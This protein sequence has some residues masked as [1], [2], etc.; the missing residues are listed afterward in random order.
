[1]NHLREDA[2]IDL[3][4]DESL[5]SSA[6]IAHLASCSECTR[7]VRLMREAF[8]TG[9]LTAGTS[10]PSSSLREHVLGLVDS[11]TRFSG[12]VD[13]VAHHFDIDRAKAASILAEI[14]RVA[15]WEVGPI[16]GSLLLHL[17]GGPRVADADAGL[18]YFESG[19]EFPRHDHRGDEDQIILQGGFREPS[20]KTYVAG[21]VLKRTKGDR[22]SFV[23]HTK[24]AC[25]VAVVLHGG[26]IELV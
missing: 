12:F 10:T 3:A 7:E 11:A 1:M 15:T 26:D 22:H 14:D 24:E 20:G 19:L 18:V 16:P 25:I 8:A 13:R 5:G 6:D 9:A 4:M 2:L 23:V 21:D 17:E